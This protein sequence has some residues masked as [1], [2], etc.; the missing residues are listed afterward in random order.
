MIVKIKNTLCGLVEFYDSVAREM[1]CTD[2]SK[3]QYDC[4]KIDIAENIQDGF[5][6]YYTALASETDPTSSE[7]DIN[8]GITMLLAI[9]GPKVNKTLKANEVKVFDGFIIK[10][11]EDAV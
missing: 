2:T 7:N 11:K 4:T 10:G 1:G 9:S 8:T 6:A 3:L 5:Y